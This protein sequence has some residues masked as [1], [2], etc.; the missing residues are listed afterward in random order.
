MKTLQTSVPD[1]CKLTKRESASYCD[2]LFAFFLQL[3]INC[4]W[5]Q[6]NCKKEEINKA[7]LWFYVITRENVD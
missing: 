1:L 6:L 4:D 2:I 5:W 3:R 7:C